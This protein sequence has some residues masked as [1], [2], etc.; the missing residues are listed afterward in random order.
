MTSRTIILAALAVF[1]MPFHAEASTSPVTQFCGDRVCPFRATIPSASKKTARA[2]RRAASRRS[3]PRRPARPS[4]KVVKT[5]QW[6]PEAQSA[7]RGGLERVETAAGI[8]ITVAADFAA[9]IKG[10]IGDLVAGGYTP[11]QIHC[12]A[13]GGHVRHSLHYSGHACDFDQRGWGKT[14][15]PMYHVAALC[16]KWGLRDGGEF[17]D[18][19]HIDSGSHLRRGSR[20]AYKL[21]H[22]PFYGAT[23]DFVARVAHH[24]RRI[25]YARR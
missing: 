21:S 2:P 5:R 3:D 24:H 11:H 23:A 7:L 20:E 6:A 12:Y 13:T 22:P 18:Y 9:P 4:R 17:R 15:A 8:T 1:A 16:R 10:F 19:G 25:R 14:A